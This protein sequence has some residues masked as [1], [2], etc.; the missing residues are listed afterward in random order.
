MVQELGGNI[1]P[2]LSVSAKVLIASL[3]SFAIASAIGFYYLAESETTRLRQKY[4]EDAGHI[5]Q[6]IRNQFFEIY[7][8]LEDANLFIAQLANELIR[9]EDVIHIEVY[10]RFERLSA[11]S[12]ME[13]T[14]RPEDYPLH[15]EFVAKVMETGKALTMEHIPE[16]LY[17]IVAPIFMA[18][19]EH[20]GKPI[21]AVVVGFRTSAR[22]RQVETKAQML[23]DIVQ[24]A[25]GKSASHLEIERLYIDSITRRLGKIKGL[26]ALTVYDNLLKTLAHSEPGHI[27]EDASGETSDRVSKVIETR[28]ELEAEDEEGQMHKYIPIVLSDEAGEDYVAAVVDIS[29]DVGYIERTV[30]TM[31]GKMFNV[32]LAI[33]LSTLLAIWIVLRATVVSPI[34][35]FSDI[36]AAVTAGDLDSKVQ[37]DSDDEFGRLAESFNRMTQEIRQS[38]DELLSARNFNQDVL[39]S[40]NESLVVIS[41]EGHVM[42]TNEAAGELLGYRLKELEALHIGAFLQGWDEVLDEVRNRGIA[43]FSERSFIA[44]DGQH[45]PVSLSASEMG[46]QSLGVIFGFVIVATDI[47]ERK[48]SE[49]ALR[50]YTTKLEAYTAELVEADQRMRE[51][52]ERFRL[53]FETGPD[54]IML[55]RLRDGMYVDINNSFV[56]MTGYPRDDV[57]GTSAY[58]DIRLWS[59][60]KERDNF[61]MALEREGELRNMPMR[62]TLRDG[63]IRE[64]LVSASVFEL[65]GAPHILTLMRDISELREAQKD[66]DLLTEQI[67]EKN[68]ELEQ[69]VYISSHDLRS[70]LVNVHGFSK[71]IEMDFEALAA[72]LEEVDLSPDVREKVEQIL[73]K[74]VPSSLSYIKSSVGKMDMQ[75]KGLLRLSRLGRAEVEIRDIDMDSLVTGV[76]DDFGF[77]IKEGGIRIDRTPLPKCLGDEGLVSQAVSNIIDNALKYMDNSRKGVIN[78]SAWKEGVMTVYCIRDNGKGI[79]EEHQ[80]K[81]FEIFHRLEPDNV[82]GEGLGLSIV[83]K[84]ISKCG[85]KVWLE[86][87]EGKGSRLYL[88]LPSA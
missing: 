18:G 85:G 2:T 7:R 24:L 4:Y 44:K 31:R 87:E 54:P 65:G 86:S 62:I 3:A 57:I 70:P 80:G 84:A 83:Q 61:L 21:G 28:D 71:E 35:R 47:R 69:L 58:E 15:E 9:L 12:Y 39:A 63:S 81:V 52:E 23:A 53:A 25:V 78:I 32:A 22:S 60:I 27:G 34:S 64:C 75:L 5:A 10:D 33:T 38:R 46:S 8:D 88:S 37:I 11:H 30:L 56:S 67:I 40:L 19:D 82:S 29:V 48:R 43:V 13:D 74:D 77:R 1:R 55:M 49:E 51:S 45:V 68:R 76:V 20:G 66:R 17:E 42:M 59:D 6:I 16:R 79:R 41:N 14:G 50:E 73:S 72:M 36:T 26:A